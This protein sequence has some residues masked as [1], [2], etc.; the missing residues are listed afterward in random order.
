MFGSFAGNEGNAYTDAANAYNEAKRR[1]VKGRDLADLKTRADST[2]AHFANK[3]S[4]A[5]Q[6]VPGKIH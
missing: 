6:R 5:D 1:G 4:G 3:L 2:Y